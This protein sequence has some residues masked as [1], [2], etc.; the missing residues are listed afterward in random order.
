MILVVYLGPGIFS[1]GVIAVLFFL[2]SGVLGEVLSSQVE[3]HLRKE[4]GAPLS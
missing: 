3:E 4:S 2:Q 1:Y